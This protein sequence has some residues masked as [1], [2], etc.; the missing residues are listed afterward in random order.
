MIILRIS[1]FGLFV[2]FVALFLPIVFSEIIRTLL[3]FLWSVQQTFA[4]LGTLSSYAG[5]PMPLY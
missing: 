1:G 4:A 5:Q 3:V 2:L